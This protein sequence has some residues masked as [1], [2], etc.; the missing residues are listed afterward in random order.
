MT[1]INKHQVCCSCGHNFRVR[2]YGS[3]NAQ[4]SPEAV[5][6]FLR[7]ELNHHECPVCHR[8]LWVLSPV[9]FHDMERIFM[10][11][12][13]KDSEADG[14][15]L[16]TGPPRWPPIIYAHNYVAA[17]IALVAFRANPSNAVVPYREIN[18]E[19][20]RAYVESY[21]R[22]YREAVVAGEA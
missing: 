22:Y 8:Q 1:S 3:I 18:A 17:L 16:Q 11:W 7:G 9:L 12:I 21:L 19:R 20:T 2:L 15:V 13:G 4:L 5:E 14:S 6:E 10:V